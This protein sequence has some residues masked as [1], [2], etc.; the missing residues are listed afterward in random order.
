MFTKVVN[1]RG[2]IPVTRYIGRPRDGSLFHFGNP[3]EIGKP[4]TTDP[5]V[6]WTRETCILAFYDWLAGDER[7]QRVDPHRRE[8]ILNN[9]E[10]L[11]GQTLGCFCAPK[12][13]HGDAYRVFLGEITYEDL[14]DLVKGKP[15]K[16]PADPFESAQSSLF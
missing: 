11:R 9:L 12:C 3:F 14:L 5:S 10:Q 2:N 16:V 15:N 7:Y 8:W 13:C 1:I 4:T 6:V